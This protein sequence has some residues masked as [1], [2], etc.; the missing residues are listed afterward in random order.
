MPKRRDQ[1]RM[2]VE[3]IWKFIEERKSLQV[4]TLNRDG[5]P[6]LTTL[7]FAIMDGD[8]VF[9]TYT[10]SQKIRN[11]ERDPRITVLVEDGD[12]Y[13]QLRG[14]S[15]SGTAEL[16]S[17]PEKVHALALEVMSRN[18]PGVS[19]EQLHGMAQKMAAKRT[20]VVVKPTRIVSWDHSKLGG[21]GL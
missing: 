11:L 1:I 13:D 17:E 3:E 8:V 6:H 20:G 15:L 14:V 19:R 18:T 12:R 16:V 9:E 10:K 4:A 5:S 2:S 21:V 7:W